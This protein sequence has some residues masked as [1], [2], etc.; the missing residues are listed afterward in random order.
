MTIIYIV[1]A[2]VVIGLALGLGLGLGL[3][4]DDSNNDGN[5]QTGTTDVSNFRTFKAPNFDVNS[6]NNKKTI[7]TAVNLASNLPD[8]KAYFIGAMILDGENECNAAMN[9][10]C[11]DCK[12]ILGTYVLSGRNLKH[13]KQ[14]LSTSYDEFVFSVYNEN[15][16]VVNLTSGN[17]SQ[18]LKDDELSFRNSLPNPKASLFTGGKYSSQTT[19]PGVVWKD[20]TIAWKAIVDS[21]GNID[22]AKSTATID[23]SVKGV[24][25]P[26]IK[27]EI[28]YLAVAPS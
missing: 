12:C 15:K 13:A 3:K 19:P 14:S 25:A 6:E 26:S 9:A 1:A 8:I 27:T 23:F 17:P 21:N 28:Y 4:K 5:D 22:L 24:N 20:P 7:S 2:I 16:H 11:N 10:G 18:T